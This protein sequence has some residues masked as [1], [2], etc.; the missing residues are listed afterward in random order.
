MKKSISL[1]LVLTIVFSS[2][3][4]FGATAS[5]ATT[6]W[7]KIADIDS[8]N[9]VTS[10][11][12][13]YDIKGNKTISFCFA[14]K[15]CGCEY[16]NLFKTGFKSQISNIENCVRFD[17]KVYRNGKLV[18]RGNNL[19]YNQKITI[20]KNFLKTCRVYITSYFVSN[21]K[22]FYTKNKGLYAATSIRY[23][24]TDTVEHCRYYLKY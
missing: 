8:R 13:Y 10:R 16:P 19:K 7:Y 15:N 14:Y 11:T 6:P 20:D 17:Y 5:A 22:A 3:F 9:K 1:L 4:M 24:G 12:D 2:C 23:M 21:G 18:K